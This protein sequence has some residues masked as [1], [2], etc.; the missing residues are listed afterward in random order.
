MAYDT[1]TATST[2]DLLDKLRIFLDANGWSVTWRFQIAQTTWRWL[3]ASKSGV[4]FNFWEQ[5]SSLSTSAPSSHHIRCA[6]ATSYASGSDAMNQPDAG[7]ASGGAGCIPPYLAYHFFEG[8]GS[9]GPYC[10]AAVEIAAGEYVHFGAGVLNKA[11]AYTGGEFACGTMWVQ[12][13]TY[14]GGSME[15]ALSQPNAW[16][17]SDTSNWQAQGTN[18]PIGTIVRCPAALSGNYAVSTRST[19]PAG[20]QLRCGGA[21]AWSTARTQGGVPSW[22][23]WRAPVIQAIAGA[24]LMRAHCFVERPSSLI[25]YI[26]EPPGLR[27]LSIEYLSHA[28]EI[29]LGTDVWKV[30]P[31]RRKGTGTGIPLSGN[32]GIAYLKN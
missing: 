18:L 25:S 6:Y 28:E 32:F 26:G 15:N 19:T 14:G 9:S 2:A 1:G 21:D 3:H 24:V 27:H 20:A 29:T 17:F 4:F 8:V 16:P 12:N 23:I 31:L 10:Y 22:A 7:L 30:F 5:L 11:G 13:N